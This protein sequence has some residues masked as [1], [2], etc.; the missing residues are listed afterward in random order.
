MDNICDLHKD[1]QCNSKRSAKPAFILKGL[2]VLGLGLLG[3]FP[4]FLFKKTQINAFY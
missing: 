4:P 2:V 3:I 1:Y